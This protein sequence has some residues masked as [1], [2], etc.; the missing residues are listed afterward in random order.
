MQSFMTYLILIIETQMK[1]QWTNIIYETK[2]NC[3]LTP[4]VIN[5]LNMIR[6]M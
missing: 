4:T 1:S 3:E 2:Q 5:L 6:N